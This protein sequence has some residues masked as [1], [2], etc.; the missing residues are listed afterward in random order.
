MSVRGHGQGSRGGA[1]P[2]WAH[3]EHVEEV[4]GAQAAEDVVD[5]LARDLPPLAGHRAARVQQDHHVLRRTSR[6][7]VPDLV[8]A[9]V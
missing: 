3:E 1:G 6:L 2:G 4:V 9:V 8:P 5:R 7:D